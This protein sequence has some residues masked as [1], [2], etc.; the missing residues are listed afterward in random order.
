M[1]NR[2]AIRSSTWRLVSRMVQ[3][4]SV[5]EV[6]LNRNSM[7]FA[8]AQ[9]PHFSRKPILAP[10]QMNSLLVRLPSTAS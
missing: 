2:G 4:T 3:P 10:L 7:Y 1:V 5:S 9:F 6:V 8:T